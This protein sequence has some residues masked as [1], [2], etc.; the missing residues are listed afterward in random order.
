[1]ETQLETTQIDMLYVFIEI[2]FS[3]LLEP[4]KHPFG[5]RKKNH[6][7]KLDLSVEYG[8]GEEGR[9]RNQQGTN[10][11][12]MFHLLNFFITFKFW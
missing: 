3:F 1:M 12:C 6:F 2:N 7:G 4:S 10:L 5:K 8:R 9:G 11:C